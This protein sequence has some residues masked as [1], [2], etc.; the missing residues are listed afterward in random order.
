MQ[1]IMMTAT[2]LKSSVAILPG[3]LAAL[4]ADVTGIVA[5]VGAF[6]I[7]VLIV[8]LGLYFRHR[9]QKLLHETIR[10]MIEKGQPIPPELLNGPAIPPE[11]M[12]NPWNVFPARVR[13]DLR[14]GLIWVGVGLALLLGHVSGPGLGNVGLIP[15]FI[16]LAYLITWAVE[17][18]SKGNEGNNDKPSA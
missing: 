2:L 8:G 7:P 16:G 6:S 3:T 10:L 13:N 17:R 12:N 5:V 14:R 1:N 18:K 15:L 4:H 11:M 9:R